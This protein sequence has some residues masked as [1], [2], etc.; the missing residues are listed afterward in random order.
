MAFDIPLSTNSSFRVPWSDIS[1]KTRYG[2]RGNRHV[3]IIVSEEPL[4]HPDVVERKPAIQ[5]TDEARGKLEHQGIPREEQCDDL[6][7]VKARYGLAKDRDIYGVEMSGP[8][9]E[10][11]TRECVYKQIASL[12]NNYTGNGGGMIFKITLEKT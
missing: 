11:L 7:I 3:L 8:G 2:A 5:L 10:R 4:D 6:T 12:M 9:G 1:G